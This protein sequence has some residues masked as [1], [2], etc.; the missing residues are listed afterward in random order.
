MDMRYASGA[1]RF[2]QYV[3]A[4]AEALP[5]TCIGSFVTL[6]APDRIDDPAAFA[7]AVE[8]LSRRTT[9]RWAKYIVLDRRIDPLIGQ[10]HKR[11]PGV[12]VQTF[13]LSPE[14]IERRI[15]AA[16]R[17]NQMTPAEQ[18]RYA[19]MMAGF[20][21]ARRDFEAAA[22]LQRTSVEAARKAD[23]P[24]D[25]ASS[26][27][28]LGNTHLA[29]EQY[30]LAETSY[31]E[32]VDICIAERADSL[33]AMVLT[34]L[35]VAVQHQGREAEADECF[36]TARRLFAGQNDCPGVGYVLDTQ[37]QA[38]RATGDRAGAERA[39]RAALDEYDR[40]SSPDFV[41][42]RASGRHN[43]EDRLRKLYA[44][45]GESDKLAALPAAC[46]VT[47]HG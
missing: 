2:A 16:L 46:E 34:N 11:V 13:H 43:V 28:N 35:G 45:M 10:L 5:A 37:G 3:S 32:A 1:V 14:E 44:E 31:A 12:S 26:L 30:A 25:V 19:G 33:L 21:F 6:L 29:A 39:W 17:Q 41:K 40:I 15:G 24:R 22:A 9:S 23:S 18:L 36:V 20:H 8:L 47:C 38:L 42:V 7:A 4:V 27:Y